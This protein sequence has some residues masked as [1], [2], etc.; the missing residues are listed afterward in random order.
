MLINGNHRAQAQFDRAKWRPMVMIPTWLLQLGLSMS[1][2][3]LFAYRLGDSMKVNKDN[4]KKNDDPTIEIVWEATNVA[5]WFVASLCSF[6][7]IAKYFAEALTPWT[8]LFTHVIKLTC[9]IATLALDIVVYTEKHDK[10]YSLVA[11]GL[12]C[13]FIITSLVLVFYSVRRYRRLSA[14][15]DYTHPVNVKP[16]GFN[17]D[18]ERDTSYARQSTDKR[19]SSTSSRASIISKRESVE[20][21][22][23]QRTPSVYSHKRDTQFDDYVARRGSATKERIGSGDFSYAGAQGEAQDSGATLTPT[24]PRGASSGRAA[25]WTSDRGLVAVP[26]EDD[27]TTAG[28]E[29]KTEKEKKDREALLGNTP[30]ESI[31][32]LVVPQEADLSEPRWQREQ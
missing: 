25:S 23:V 4:D 16:Y 11:L 14:Y 20:M 9:A 22:T 8:M 12:D 21:G 32:G 26:E 19:F 31:D 28:K 1:M 27:D 29:S 15:D 13:A 3:G 2:M 5:L 24:R 10:H 6:V 7:E 30:R 18:L 17:D